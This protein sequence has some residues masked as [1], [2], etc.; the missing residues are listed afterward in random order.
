MDLQELFQSSFE[1]LKNNTLRTLLT[2]LG[3]IIGISSVILIF[4]IGQ[5]AVSFVTNELSMFGTN[6]F[7][8]NPGTDTLS[9]IMG[10][11][12]TLSLDD[13]DAIRKDTS[14]TN[15]QSVGAFA[16]VSSTV[17]ANNIDKVYLLYGMS[18]EI[19]DMLKPTMVEGEFLTQENNLEEQRVVVIGEKAKETFFGTNTNVLGENIK[20]GQKTFKIVGV[21]RSGSVLFGSFFDSALFLPLNVVLHQMG[22]H[23]YIREI[24]VSVKDTN[25]M[26]ETIGQVTDLLRDR[27]NLKA[28]EENDFITASA[29]DALSTVQTITNVLTLIISAIGA[30]SLVVGGVGVMNIMLVSVTERTREIGLLKAIGAQEKDILLQFLI[31]AVVMTGIGG[32]LGIILGILG[33]AVISFAVGIPL[34]VNPLSI[35]V[36]VAVSMLVGI[37][38]G[39]YPA[40]RAARLSPIDALRYE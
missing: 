28:N 11:A 33:A 1:S 29:T 6:F 40:R 32:I 18:P 34:V 38:F 27:H 15:I 17:T 5:G 2:M 39:L 37:I 7:Q 9:A 31:E 26:N 14:L 22:G 16:N 8:I 13:V 25:L 21:A 10:G 24:D 4:S 23:P 3:I 36:A 35:F 20:I 30:I 19:V 12:E